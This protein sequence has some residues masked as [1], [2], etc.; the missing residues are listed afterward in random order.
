MCRVIYINVTDITAEEGTLLIFTRRY[1]LVNTK[2]TSIQSR[3]LVVSHPRLWS[4]KATE[5]LFC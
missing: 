1:Q 5:M 2:I 3:Q 4:Y